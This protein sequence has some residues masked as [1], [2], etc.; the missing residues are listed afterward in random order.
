M[1]QNSRKVGSME[2]VE[3]NGDIYLLSLWLS[4]YFLIHS[5]NKLFD[6]CQKLKYIYLVWKKVKVLVYQL[7]PTLCD[8]MDCSL[9]DCFVHG[10]LQ[11]RVL[12]WI[13]IPFSGGSFQPRDQTWVSHIVGRF[14]TVWATREAL[15]LR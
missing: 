8:P 7:C 14:F 3:E 2:K 13:A 11:A 10:I 6:G 4:G 1:K 5:F 12:E 15:K 9:P